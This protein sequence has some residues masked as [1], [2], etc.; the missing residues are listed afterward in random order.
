[1]NHTLKHLTSNMKI[2]TNQSCKL[3]S[4]VLIIITIVTRKLKCLRHTKL[5]HTTTTFKDCFI[6]VFV[7]HYKRFHFQSFTTTTESC[8]LTGVPVIY[9]TQ[10]NSELTF[11]HWTLGILV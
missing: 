1:M 8:Q 2:F 9:V 5:L 6:A 11:P 7:L 10:Q 4:N 3:H